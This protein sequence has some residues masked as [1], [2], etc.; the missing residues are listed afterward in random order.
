[1]KFT[2]FLVFIFMFLFFRK[3]LY[4]IHANV[5]KLLSVCLS[6]SISVVG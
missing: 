2:A 4:R 1:M 5:L 6:A 3:E